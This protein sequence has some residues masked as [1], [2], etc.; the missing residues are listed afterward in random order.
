MWLQQVNAYKLY[1]LKLA[2]TEHYVL[3]KYSS[4]HRT[5]DFF[6]QNLIQGRIK[7]LTCQI[8]DEFLDFAHWHHWTFTEPLVRETALGL[9]LLL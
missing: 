8:Q 9:I 5:S 1:N 4:E 7:N 3:V 2:E 6:F